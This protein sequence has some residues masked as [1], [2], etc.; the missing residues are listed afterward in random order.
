MSPSR[1][2][3][4][5]HPVGIGAT[6]L[7]AA[8]PVP[9][10][11]LVPVLVMVVVAF[12]AATAAPSPAAARTTAGAQDPTV[13]PGA[14]GDVPVVC[15]DRLE[16]FGDDA[17]EPAEGPTGPDPTVGSDP[18]EGTRVAAELPPAASEVGGARLATPGIHYEADTGVPPPPVD[19]VTAWIVADLDT[20][21]VVAACNAHVPL[22][23]ASTLKVL[24]A[25]ALFDDVPFDTPYVATDAAAG[26]DGSRAGLVPGLSYRGEDLWYGLLLGS[27]NDCAVA[28]AELTGGPEIAAAQLN[29]TAADLGAL[30]T[31]AVNTSGLDAPGQVSSAYDLALLGRAALADP[32]VA[33]ILGATAYAFPGAPVDEAGAGA[34]ATTPGAAGERGTFQIQNHNR[35][36]RNYD[37]AT[38]VKNGWTSA[39]GGSFVG[40]AERDGRRY[41]VALLR[42]DTSTWRAAAALLD[43][44]F[45][46]GPR[47]Q[48]VGELVSGRP[49]PEPVDA[50]GTVAAERPEPRPAAAPESTG[51]GPG[52]APAEPDGPAGLLG[53]SELVA[54]GGAV[55]ALAAGLVL[56]RR[57]RP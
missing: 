26:V 46:H 13:P 6:P 39:A 7:P 41:V 42:A 27:G 30:D 37:G 54:A 16:P 52:V 1:P 49:D 32:G 53:S 2:G 20:G 22:A 24:T 3:D 38:G 50:T 40:S 23:P 47:L 31:R 28:L 17:A 44:A 48:P 25:L 57:G 36:L 55:A 45:T 10:M 18:T 11:V 5:I 34:P 15:P 9:V 21:A 12:V 33:P 56:M 8:L 14:S 4:P 19:R 51:P 29:R 35:L 43:W